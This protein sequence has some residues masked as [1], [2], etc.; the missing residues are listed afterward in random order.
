MTGFSLTKKCPRH[1][2]ELNGM[3][4][5]TSNMLYNP[6]T[7]SGYRWWA[8]YVVRFD[9]WEQVWWLFDEK[10]IGDGANWEMA[11][12]LK[13]IGLE[14]GRSEYSKKKGTWSAWKKNRDRIETPPKCRNFYWYHSSLVRT[15]HFKNIKIA[16]LRF[17][18][19]RSKSIIRSVILWIETMVAR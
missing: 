3:E 7:A 8:V 9:L 5:V 12:K 10:K 15:D 1:N 18:L 17:K 13:W 16:K 14:W 11:H 19:M 4:V 2:V 6:D